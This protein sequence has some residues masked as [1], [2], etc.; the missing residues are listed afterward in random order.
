MAVAGAVAGVGAPLWTSTAG[1]AAEVAGDAGIGA[2]AVRRIGGAWRG[3][4]GGRSLLAG[5]A[6]RSVSR[7]S[8][9]AAGAR[10]LSRGP[11]VSVAWSGRVVPS[12]LTCQVAP[13][14]HGPSR[15]PAMARREPTARIAASAVAMVP[16]GACVR[17]TIGGSG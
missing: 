14:L 1:G 13:A 5:R 8:P 9:V 10:T 3:G 7:R 11:V 15:T 4:G 2:T 16:S 17:N 12:V 6:W